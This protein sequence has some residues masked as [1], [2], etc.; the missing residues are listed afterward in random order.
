MR[1]APGLTTCFAQARLIAG[2]GELA[3]RGELPV[4]HRNLGAVKRLNSPVA[5]EAFHPFHPRAFERRV[6]GASSTLGES[7]YG[8]VHA[9]RK[10]D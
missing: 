7:A 10:T 2:V 5:I 1:I 8:A 4:S 6:R 3:A 9:K